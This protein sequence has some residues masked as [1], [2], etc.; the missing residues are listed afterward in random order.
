VKKLLPALLLAVPLAALAQ[1]EFAA[2]MR[3]E[4]ARWPEFAKATGLKLD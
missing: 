1:D 4:S 3:T 2:N